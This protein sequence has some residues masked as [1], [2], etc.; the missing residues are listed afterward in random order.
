MNTTRVAALLL[1]AGA[2]ACSSLLDVKNPN[3]VNES[4]LSNPASAA[5]QANGVLSSVARAW[6]IVLTP[7]AMVTDE[8]TWIGSRDALQS[9]DF[10][11]ES[12]PTKEFLDAA[13]PYVGEPRG[14][15]SRPSKRRE[16]FA[17]ATGW[18]DTSN[19]NRR[20]FSG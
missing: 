17:P 2:A 9:L 14:W 15:S 6:G 1:V 18:R 3:N 11:R 19:L 10:G 12:E 13:F 7:Y 4:D 8:L 20:Y 16:G 5:T